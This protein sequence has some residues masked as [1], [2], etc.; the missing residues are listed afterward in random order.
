MNEMEF[1][2]KLTPN[3]GKEIFE[4]FLEYLICGTFNKIYSIQSIIDA[5]ILTQELG[6]YNT[7]NNI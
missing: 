1:C 6:L 5:R 7:S 4:I 3:D 2:R